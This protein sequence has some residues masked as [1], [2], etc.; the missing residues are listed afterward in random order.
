MLRASVMQDVG[1]VDVS[2]RFANDME[3]W[4]RMASVSDVGR[5]DGPDQALHR[6]HAASLSA[7]EGADQLLDLQERASVFEAFFR[8][9]GGQLRRSS[10]LHALARR[11]LAA[12]ALKHAYHAYDRG[13]TGTV[14]VGSYVE[15]ALATYPEVRS[16]PQ[17][18]ALQ[19]RK[20][21][22]ARLAPLTPVFIASVIWRRLQWETYRRRWQRS[23]V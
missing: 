17:W 10:E 9:R 20:K 18:R 3:M 21:V 23:G 11:A 19:R 5:I 7:T 13:R 2:L 6:E 14:D 4:L 22:G 12:E 15:F 8:G 1:G 16:L